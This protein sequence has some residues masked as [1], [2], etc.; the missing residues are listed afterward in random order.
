MDWFKSVKHQYL[1]YSLNTLRSYFLSMNYSWFRM[2]S[3]LFEWF[4]L[5]LVISKFRIWGTYGLSNFQLEQGYGKHC[6]LFYWWLDCKEN[7]E[8]WSHHVAWTCNWY[9]R[10]VVLGKYP[11]NSIVILANQTYNCKPCK[12]PPAVANQTFPIQARGSW[13]KAIQQRRDTNGH[14]ARWSPCAV[15]AWFRPS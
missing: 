12:V 4:V 8:L 10:S 2:N 14:R 15:L 1:M 3:E 13:S 9:Y 5:A 11:I 7:V 6:S